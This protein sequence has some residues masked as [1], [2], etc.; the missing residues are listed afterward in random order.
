M[1]KYKWQ[2]PPVLALQGHSHQS[3]CPLSNGSLFACFIMQ[4]L[5]L[6]WPT[7]VQPDHFKSGGYACALIGFA[8]H[9]FSVVWCGMLGCDMY[10]SIHVAFG[11]SNS[12]QHS[13][14]PQIVHFNYLPLVVSV[15]A[16]SQAN[17]GVL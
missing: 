9:I 11:S 6:G 3:G 4:R 16:T 7:V 17:T 15:I 8:C 12:N 13:F 5:H 10:G 1:L 2:I 14:L